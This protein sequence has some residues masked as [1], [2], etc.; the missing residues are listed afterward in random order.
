MYTK[1]PADKESKMPSVMSAPGLWGL[2][3]EAIPAPVATPKG[4]V[5]AKKHDIIVADKV[6]N[7]AW[8]IHPPS[9]NPSKNWWNDN[10]T[11][12]GLMVQGLWET[13]RDNPIII[14]WDT[15]PSSNT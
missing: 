11:I 3:T 6:L 1:I 4:V 8:E 7:W 9:A 13:P 10:A 14:E 5:S 2:K 12:R 15:I